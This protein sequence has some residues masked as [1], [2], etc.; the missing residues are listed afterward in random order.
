MIEEA[1]DKFAK[2]EKKLEG[3]RVSGIDEEKHTATWSKKV[4]QAGAVYIQEARW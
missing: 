2:E 1:L 3:Y 4:E